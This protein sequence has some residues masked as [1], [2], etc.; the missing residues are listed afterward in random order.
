M[1]TIANLQRAAKDGGGT[2]IV[3]P[4][5]SVKF[6]PNGGC[7]SMTNVEGTNGGKMPCGALLTMLGET[8]P[9]YCALCQENHDS[10]EP[11]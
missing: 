11:A 8:K 10:Q 3:T 4:V 9:Y 7:G 6:G 2:L 1:K 5:L